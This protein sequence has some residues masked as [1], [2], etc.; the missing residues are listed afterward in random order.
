MKHACRTKTHVLQLE[1]ESANI[2]ASLISRVNQNKQKISISEHIFDCQGDPARQESIVSQL[3]LAELAAGLCGL[4]SGGSL[5]IK[6]FTF[7]QSASGMANRTPQF[8]F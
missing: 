8:L 1:S 6:M 2:S 7:F 3:H 4:K 5:V